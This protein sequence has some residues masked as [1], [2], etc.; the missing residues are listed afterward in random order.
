[1][2]DPDPL[3]G[4]CLNRRSEH[5]GAVLDCPLSRTV[6]PGSRFT[7]DL[8]TETPPVVDLMGALKKALDSLSPKDTDAKR[9]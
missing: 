2:S 5:Y 6:R 9:E 4:R 1:L 3:C 7:E 8:V